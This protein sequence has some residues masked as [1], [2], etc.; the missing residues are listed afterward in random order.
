[1][2]LIRFTLSLV[3]YN[4]TWIIDNLELYPDLEIKIY[5]KW[6]VL[7]NAQSKNYIPWEGNHKN[8]PLPSD[9]YYYIINLN[10]PNREILNGVITII[11]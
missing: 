4:D 10:K 7:I 6:G 9:S 5:N 8:N 11:R 1:M 3:Q 2:G